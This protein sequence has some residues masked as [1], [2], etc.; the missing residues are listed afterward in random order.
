[1]APPRFVAAVAAALSCL[2]VACGGEETPGDQRAVP[3]AEFKR[4]PL[5]TR[6]ET[7]EQKFGTPLRIEPAGELDPGATCLFYPAPADAEPA[8]A[9]QLCFVD[10]KLH[11]K[12]AG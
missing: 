5:D 8:T 12:Y 2:A 3:F 11:S 6:R 7:V 1:M 4:L 9:Y 10:G